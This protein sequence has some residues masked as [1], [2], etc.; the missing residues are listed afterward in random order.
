MKE[1]YLKVAQA[2]AQTYGKKE[3]AE[4]FEEFIDEVLADKEKHRIKVK[5]Q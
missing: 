5:G 1:I 2:L 3:G 4:T